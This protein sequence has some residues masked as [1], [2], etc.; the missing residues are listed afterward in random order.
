MRFS[1]FGYN[2]GLGT[3]AG[4]KRQKLPL[5]VEARVLAL[6][7]LQDP[8]Q[9]LVLTIALLALIAKRHARSLVV[10]LL[11]QRTILDL[12]HEPRGLCLQ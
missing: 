3:A 12:H 11:R 9:Q 10:F 7:C 8:N 5:G 1:P 6:H 4:S 2:V